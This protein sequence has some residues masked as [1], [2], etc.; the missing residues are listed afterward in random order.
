METVM[1]G[2]PEPFPD[3]YRDGSP[4][5]MPR[6]AVPQVLIVGRD[7]DRAESTAQRLEPRRFARR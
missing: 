6:L 3:R 7:N 5:E 1:G 4:I 2:P